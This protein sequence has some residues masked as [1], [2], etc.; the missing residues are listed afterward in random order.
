MAFKKRIFFFTFFIS[1][2]V[3]SQEKQIENVIFK[4]LQKTKISFLKRF[5]ETKSNSR[6]DSSQLEKDIIRL[7]RLPAFTNAAY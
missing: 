7:K 5:L 4:G 2:V 1:V 3:F 6:L